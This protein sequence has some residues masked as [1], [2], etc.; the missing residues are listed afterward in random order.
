[1]LQ[2][3]KWSIWIPNTLQ[4]VP[5]FKR[6]R[7]GVDDDDD[8]SS[9]LKWK[10]SN[11]FRQNKKAY[12]YAYGPMVDPMTPYNRDWQFKSR[13]ASWNISNIMVQT[14]YLAKNIVRNYFW[15][16]YIKGDFSVDQKLK[17]DFGQS[18]LCFT[19]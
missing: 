4:P 8:D 16:F 15:I 10:F 14:D 1:M 17:I 2:K 3:P 9:N 11:P 19:T 12:G 7:K 18:A 13:Y 6:V 5:I